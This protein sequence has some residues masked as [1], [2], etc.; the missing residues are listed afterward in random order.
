MVPSQHLFYAPKSLQREIEGLRRRR[1]LGS[2]GQ[3]RTELTS[4]DE[5]RHAVRSSLTCK[6]EMFK[7]KVVGPASACAWGTANTQT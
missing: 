3:A 1:V 4:S 6:Q 2:V 7:S 5:P